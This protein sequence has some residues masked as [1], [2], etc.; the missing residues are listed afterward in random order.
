MLWLDLGVPIFYVGKCYTQ[1]TLS[2]L[3][4][5]LKTTP[6]ERNVDLWLIKKRKRSRLTYVDGIPQIVVKVTLVKDILNIA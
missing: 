5:S 6:R 1:V 2:L 3:L 4:L